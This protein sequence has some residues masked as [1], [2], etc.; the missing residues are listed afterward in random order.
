MKQY[1]CILTLLICVSCAGIPTDALNSYNKSFQSFNQ[2][3]DEFLIQF[4]QTIN[5]IEK[6][7]TD[8]LSKQKIHF[9]PYPSSIPRDS[10][11]NTVDPN[12]A[13]MKKTLKVISNY[14]S[15]LIALSEGKSVEAVGNTA[16]GLITALDGLAGITLPLNV[17]GLVVTIGQE[18]ERARL[19][20]EFRTA[21]DK[22]SP[23]IL[24][25]FKIIEGNIDTHYNSNVLFTNEARTL[26][27]TEAIDSVTSL[28]KLVENY[29][30]L[31]KIL[32]DQNKF[33]GI[34][35]WQK[36]LD[37]ILFAISKENFIRDKYPYLLTTNPSGNTWDSVVETNVAN[38]LNDLEQL[39]K[40]YTADIVRM[41]ALANTLSNYKKMLG[42]T[43]STLITLVK[44]EKAP[45]NILIQAQHILD[46]AFKVK[47]HLAEIRSAE[48]A[49]N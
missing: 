2:A 22:G 36:E 20:Q 41:N 17:T 12:V 26:I 35:K 32:I 15:T 11:Q 1:F 25:M 4:D 5:L 6:R 9:Q 48:A 8:E 30:E 14:N 23:I 45:E 29:K 18:L 33:K 31:D 37:R 3:S 40:K 19:H 46:L 44:A 16:K 34:P 10:E 13:V 42:L 24:Q 7:R 28:Q 47:L 39:I 21:L 38:S 27:V 43:N 49:S